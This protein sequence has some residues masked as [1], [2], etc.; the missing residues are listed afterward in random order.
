MDD[1]DTIRTHYELL[2]PS[3]DERERRLFAASL[4]RSLGRG[5][6]KLVSRATGIARSTINRGLKDIDRGD[7]VDDRVRRQG[8]GRKSILTYDPSVLN[9]LR[10]I[11]DPATRGD[12]E[13][14]LK[15]VSKSLAKLARALQGLGHTIGS[16]T[17]SELLEK[18]EYT[19]KGN[20]KTVEAANHP[21]RN[22]Q[23]EHINAKVIEYQAASH[24]VISVDTKKKELIGNFK[25]PGT[26]WEPKGRPTPVEVHD[27]PKKEI[28]QVTDLGTD[29]D[30]TTAAVVPSHQEG[31]K[32]VP[33]GVYDP[34]ANNGWVSV[35]ISHDT[36]EFAV[37]GIRIWYDRM[38]KPRYPWASRLLI[39]ADGG[40]SNGSRVRLW[41]LELQ[42]L[43]DETGIT[44][45]VCHYPPGTSKWN[46]IE[47]RMFCHI[48]QNWRAHP[49]VSRMTVV[50]LIAATTTKT[51]LIVAAELDTRVYEKG[52]KVTDAE[53]ASLNIQRDE[54]HPEWNYVI[55]PRKL[56]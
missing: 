12:P 35:G 52:R 46:K 55:A 29:T 32:V 48:S 2:R 36:A 34:S 45:E 56:E 23:F 43:A 22:A 21:D 49:L 24:P 50:D 38:G 54:F 37:N 39:T 5:G 14:P 53:M 44:I 20:R 1:K 31:G 33:Y 19:R 10:Q 51:G 6:I 41:K 47:H 42:K 27:F 7:C 8:A 13:Q 15:W 26:E 25:N 40:G 4:A 3:L 16:T 11:V 18:L 9:D 28:S 30:G 17:V